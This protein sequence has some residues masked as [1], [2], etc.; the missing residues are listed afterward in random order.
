ML[1]SSDL[2]VSATLV[3]S[4]LNSNLI[5][6]TLPALV[7]AI[8]AP[9]D[10]VLIPNDPGFGAQWHLDNLVYPGVDLNV[11]GVW[12]DYQGNGVVVGIVDTGIDYNHPDLAPNYRADL[13]YDARDGDFDSFAS[14]SNDDHGTVVAGVIAASLGHGDAVGVAPSAEITGFRLGFGGDGDMAQIVTQMQNMAGVDIANNSWGF[15]GLFY[16]DFATATFASSGA[17]IRNAAESGRGGLGTVVTFAAGNSAQSGDDVNYHSFQSSRFTIATGAIERDGDI[18]YFST[19]GAAVLVSAPGSGIYSTDV[20][21]AGGYSAGDYTTLNGTSFAAPGV[22]GVAALMLEANADLG[23]RDVQEILAYS[24]VNPKSS[25]AGWQTNGASAWNGGGLTFSHD[26]G[27]GLVDAHAAVRLAETWTAQSTE[28]NVEVNPHENLTSSAFIPDNST[29]TRTADVATAMNIDHVEVHL[30]IEHTYIG[31]LTVTLTSPDDTTS[32]LVNRPG[33][34][35]SST[36][37]ASQNDIDFTFTSVAHWGETGQGA[38]TLSVSDAVSSD[39]GYLKDWDL[40]FFGDAITGDDTYIF[41]D[42]WARYGGDASRQ[43]L[44][45]VSGLDTLNFASIT[46]SLDLDLTPGSSNSLLGH[47]LNIADGSLFEN[48]YGGDAGD[49]ISGNDADNLLYGMRGDDMLSGGFGSD[50]LIGGVG[51]DVLAGGLGVDTARYF[52][53][54]A[55]YSLTFGGADLIVSGGEGVDLLSDI[56]FLAFADRTVAVATVQAANDTVAATEDTALTIA[57]SDLLANDTDP[58]GATLTITGVGGAANGSVAL[59]GAGDVV[60]TPDADF[61][62]ADSFGYTI[63]SDGGSTA[64]GTVTVNVDAVADIPTVSAGAGQP[65]TIVASDGSVMAAIQLTLQGD[66]GDLDGSESLTVTLSGLPAGATMDAGSAAGAGGWTL[67]AGELG[68]VGLIL[69]QN[70]GGDF[71]VTATAVS[72][73]AANGDTASASAAV[74]VDM[75]NT[76]PLAVAATA[77][78]DEDDVLAG[79]IGGADFDGDSLIYAAVAQ[80]LHGSVVVGAGGAYS[81]TPNADYNGPDSFTFSVSDGNGGADAASVI[82]SVSP[83][84]DAPVANADAGLFAVGPR[85]VFAA[86]DLLANDTDVDGDSLTVQSAGN[87]VG[88][89]V[90]LDGDGNL[91]FAPDAGIEGAASFDYTASDGLGGASTATVDLFAVNPVNLVAGTPGSDILEGGSGDDVFYGL[92]GDDVLLGGAGD[93][94]YVTRRGDGA[95]VIRDEATTTETTSVWVESGSW[96]HRRNSDRWKDTS[97]WESTTAVVEADAGTDTLAFASGITLGDVV[98]ALS[99]PDLVVG[100]RDPLAPDTAFGALAD[101]VTIAN[102]ADTRDRVESLRFDDGGVVD[103][104]GLSSTLEAM[105]DTAGVTLSGGGGMDWIA[106]GSGGDEL[107]G[108]GGGDV[109]AGGSGDD[110]L[111][112]GAGDD[113]LD[114]GDGTDTAAYSG[115]FADYNVTLGAGSATVTGADG[116]DLLTGVERLVFA[117]L[118][119]FSDGTNNAPIVTGSVTLSMTEDGALSIGAATLLANAIDVDGDTLAIGALT[120]GGGL[121][122]LSDNGGGFWTFTPPAE[123]S[124]TVGLTYTVSDGAA[125]VTAA[126]TVTVAPVNDAPIAAADTASTAEDTALTIAAGDLLANDSDAEGDTLAIVS[127]GGATAGTVALDANGDVVFAPAA[128]FNGAASFA[129]TVSDGRGGTAAATATVTVTPVNDAP[130]AAA[131]SVSATEDTALTILAADLIGN[132]ADVDGDGL[133]LISVGDPVGGAVSLDAGGD[134][135]F[136]P[137]ADFSGAARFDYTVS[138]GRGGTASATA[139]V[140]VA[141]VNDAP[142]AAADSIA[143][144]EDTALTI[145]AAE[146]LGNDTDVDGDTL[147]IVWV[148]NAVSGAA[149]LDAGG[150]VVFTPAAGF[151]GAAA[152]DYTVSDGQGGSATATA[153]VTVAE[154]NDAPTPAVDSA[155]TEEDTTLTLLA[156]ALLS[157]DGDPEGDALVLTGVGNAVGGTVL[158]DAGG[159]VLF[160]PAADFNGAATFDY[161][162]SDGQGTASAAVTVTVTPVNDAPVAIDASVITDAGVPYG[163]TLSA[164]DV[165]GDGLSYTLSAAAANGVATVAADGGFVYVPGDG[166]SGDDSFTFSASDG[167]V[168]STGVVSVTV[169]PANLVSGTSGSD[170]LSGGAGDDVLYGFGGDDVLLGGAGD[171]RYVYRRGDGAD[172]IRDEETTTTTTVWVESGYW[173]HRR[174]SDKWKDTSHWETTTTVVETDAGADVLAFASGIALADVVLALSGADLVVGIRDPLAPDTA[175]GALADRITIENWTDAR[176]RVESLQFGDGT[177]IGISALSSTLEALGDTA[178]ATLTG[179]GA[180]W[181]AGGS[182]DDVLTGGGGADVITGGAGADTAVYGGAFADYTVTFGSGSVTVAGAEGV[183]LLA[184]VE[185]LTF[186]DFSLFTDGANNAPVAAADSVSTAEDTALTILASAL[187]SND[188]DPEGDAL[189]LTAVGNAVG[190][191]V[192]LDAVGDLLFTPAPDFNGAATFNY[193]VSNGQGAATAVVTVTVTPVNDAPVATDANVITDIGVPYGGVLAARDVDGDALSYALSAAAANGVATVAADGS[194]VYTPGGG[195]FGDDSFTYTASDGLAGSTGVVSV[196]V[197][198][199]NLVSG[200]SGSDVLSGGAGDDVLY[201]FGGDDVLLG[202]AGDD[203]YV[204]RRGDGADVIRDEETTTTTTKVWVESGY[205]KH[206]R[207]SDKWKDTSHWETTTTAVE[208]DAGAD[209]LAFASGIG[210]A[211]VVLALSGADLVVGIHDPLALDAAFGAL[212]DRITIE[213]WADARDRVESLQFGDGTTFDISALSSTLEALGGTAGAT[214]TGGGGADWIAGGSGDD[215]LDGGGGGDFLTGGPGDELFVFADGDGA[216]TITDFAAGAGAGDVLDLT[217]EVGLDTFADVQA[218]ASQVGSDTFIDLGGEDSVTLLGVSLGDLS[219]DDVLF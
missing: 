162:V 23:Y 200:T 155:T 109:I 38:W 33:V 148:G 63:T 146:L 175:F 190:G 180:D 120:V 157:N 59:D 48:V 173:K 61:G 137:A 138:D 84:N 191:A 170:V 13:D 133:A 92:G 49:V 168:V 158:L 132:D 21:G 184:G 202:G 43:T 20:Q 53:N 171:D 95:D 187:L 204:Y 219:P 114:G 154:V 159:D 97:H 113:R 193:T 6:A 60:Y 143:A 216:D 18:A 15:G 206:R 106:G 165:D 195:F 210:Q 30:E 197:T 214:L 118:S 104:S 70:P 151:T 217:G 164:I 98:L 110:R 163:G 16:D 19:P 181:I 186:A 54:Y 35:A 153:T 124:G 161:T 174:H 55:D 188:D 100:L 25:D 78:L 71:A 177:T 201:G 3:R 119:I 152:F 145:G 22:A 7:P 77:A 87:A 56:E 125:A 169:T 179:G 111:D 82:L 67:S 76:A 31:D 105:G 26:Y 211:D 205:W 66:L 149:S 74:T 9:P 185:Q 4:E 29:I 183:D 28:A 207:H 24:A 215:R 88:G 91:V 32:V 128:N 94:R 89:A 189:T 150:G 116:A 203:R 101:R 72:V 213:N 1:F 156:T 144:T 121:G 136:T 5:S 108:G 17:A 126:A 122:S 75:S 51:N 85:Q 47:A 14:A 103:I 102:W 42:Q 73:E 62:G 194:F 90:S 130:V 107:S 34:S 131:D 86:G 117:D 115:A 10:L 196:T 69:A 79:Q 192:S 123:Y 57:A 178:G 167:F 80:P 140:T 41:T 65:S 212:T 36:Y 12:D 127:V 83:V 182:G 2:E 39:T 166:F 58:S 93:D 99:G 52:G 176:D 129:Y 46:Q 81:Y 209:V 50:F 45:D 64:T 68:A 37:G 8:V 44:T 172:V 160:T 96:I 134:V 142:L 208:T 218:A 141:P 11:T 40:T 147:S 27:F 112:G 135:V 199:A 139:A 198:P